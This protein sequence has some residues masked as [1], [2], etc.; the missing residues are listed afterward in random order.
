M[1][2]SLEEPEVQYCRHCRTELAPALLTCPTCHRLVY[3]SELKELAA[4]AQ[5]AMAVND[6]STALAMWRTALEFLPPNTRQH[7]TISARVQELS[8]Q[9]DGSGPT[10]PPHPDPTESSGGISKT[11]WATGAAGLGP[12]ALLLWKFKFI[13][14]FVLAKAQFLLLGLTKLS[15]L[16]SMFASLG[17]Y[18][19][20][21]G[22]KFALGLVLSIYVHEMGHVAALRKFG[23]RA[24]APMFIPGFGAVVRF[25]QHLAN[26]REDSRVGLAGPIYGLAAAIAA[27]GVFLVFGWPAWAA[28]ARV[29]AWINLF[30]LIPVWQL[31]GA[32]GFHSMSRQ[33]RWLAV[34]VIASMWFLT[35]EVMLLIILVC[36]VWQALLPA[37]KEPDGIG[38]LQY[39]V[40]I[41]ILSTMCLIPVPGAAL[42]P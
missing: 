11:A 42:D 30:N 40:L 4:H 25:K 13:T 5:E 3:A 23:I 20:L 12:L 15:T 17:L 41:I 29:G 33:Q 27:Y 36:A 38:L 19:T 39:A 37:P 16:L 14:V 32:R 24:T 10:A 7:E 28:I 21:F 8:A 22:W 1:K 26:P 2:D 31:D 6:F 35:A 18:W 34:V 9:V